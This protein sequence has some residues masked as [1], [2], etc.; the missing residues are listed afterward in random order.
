MRVDVKTTRNHIRVF[1]LIVK[2]VIRGI[3]TALT[4]YTIARAIRSTSKERVGLS[5]QAYKT[6]DGRR[7]M[8]KVKF[9]KKLLTPASVGVAN[10]KKDMMPVAMA[11]FVP[12]S[13]TS[14]PI[15]S[16]LGAT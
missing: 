10:A 3:G 11:S 1:V 5:A 8:V 14:K 2:R 4:T 16:Q 6:I 15:Y 13:R 9:R 12:L 7:H